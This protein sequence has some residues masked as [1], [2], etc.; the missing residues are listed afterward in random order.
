MKKV[1]LLLVFASSFLLTSCGENES[2]PSIDSLESSSISQAESESSALPTETI[3]GDTSRTYLNNALE[4]SFG[5]KGYNVEIS[6]FKVDSLAREYTVGNA[7]E[8]GSEEHNLV[9]TNNTD[10]YSILAPKAI[11][12]SVNRDKTNHA[13]LGGYFGIKDATYIVTE[14]NQQKSKE[15][16]QYSNIYLKDNKYYYNYLN[17]QGVE[18]PGISDK[19]NDIIDDIASIIGEETSINMGT[20]GYI[21]IEDEDINELLNGLMPRT[22]FTEFMPT[23][24]DAVFDNLDEVDGVE[25][26][27]EGY[28][29]SQD[30]Y[31]TTTIHITDPKAIFHGVRNM[32]ENLP[33]I[34][35]DVLGEDFSL[36]DIL[37]IFDEFEEYFDFAKKFDLSIPMPSKEM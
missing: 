26:L 5:K 8:Q 11:F 1:N 22:S 37:E 4:T 34:I 2:T 24:V 21:E 14:N 20:K 16:H 31:Y 18:T 13:E 33:D 17:D 6:S 9:K 36:D 29:T 25:F 15:E 32:I 12:T 23:I 19:I 7:T 10:G 28:K 27:Y 30:K 3:K 35:D